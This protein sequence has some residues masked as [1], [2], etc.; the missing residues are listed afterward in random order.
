MLRNI[1][2]LTTVSAFLLHMVLGCCLHHAHAIEKTVCE[3]P[4]A[5]ADDHS[6]A[7]HDD[8]TSSNSA[9]L[10]TECPAPEDCCTG[11]QCVFLMDGN[12]SLAKLTT[13]AWLPLTPLETMG[14]FVPYPIITFR[15]TGG[16]LKSP[17]RLHLLH[18]VMLI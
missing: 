8:Q 15:D 17:T 3:H 2:S 12:V 4:A 10:P 14:T 18:Q 9:E 7:G 13:M 5:A 6:H 16:I 1:L 11:N